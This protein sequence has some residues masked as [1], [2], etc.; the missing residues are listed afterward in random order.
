[1]TGTQIEAE[2]I[3]HREAAFNNYVGFYRINDSQ[4]TI[5]DPLTGI[6]LT[7]GQEGYTQAAV[8][9]RIAGID[10]T[11]ENQGTSVISG[12]F[13]GGFLFA[14]FI[15]ANGQPDQLLDHNLRNHPAVY[16]PFLGANSDGIDHI[17]LLGDNLFGFEDLPQ[18]GDFD[19]NDITVEMN[20]T[21]V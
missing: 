9:N 11:V 5:I 21:I 4:G 3:V 10:L 16:F 19:Y 7:P 1:L 2:F 13:A 17:S 15:I 6:A 12:V 14:P 8:Q 18:G 20:L